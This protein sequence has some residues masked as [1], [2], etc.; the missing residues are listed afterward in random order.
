MTRCRSLRALATAVEQ[1]LGLNQGAGPAHRNNGH[2]AVDQNVQLVA[3]RSMGPKK[4][5]FCI[6]TPFTGSRITIRNGNLT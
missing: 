4:K 2:A 1:Q 6:H 5:T 3:Q